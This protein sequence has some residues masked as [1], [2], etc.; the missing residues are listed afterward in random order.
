LHCSNA[1]KEKSP[2]AKIPFLFAQT[3]LLLRAAANPISRAT[4][5]L[6]FFADL[7]HDSGDNGVWQIMQSA[8]NLRFSTSLLALCF[9]FVKHFFEQ[10]FLPL[11]LATVLLHIQQVQILSFF[12]LY[13]AF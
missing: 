6:H 2:S 1:T 7:L 11:K 3:I 12:G 10:Y 8:V 4:H 5:L 13:R 9:A